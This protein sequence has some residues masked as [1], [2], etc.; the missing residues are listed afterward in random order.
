MCIRDVG[1]KDL[2][3]KKKKKP[4]M[5]GKYCERRNFR[6]VHIFAHFVQRIRC[7]KNIM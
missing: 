3:K 1:N 6:A 7:A 4:N 5:N 2:K